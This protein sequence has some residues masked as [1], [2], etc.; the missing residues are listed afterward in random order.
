VDLDGKKYLA[1]VG[2]GKHAFVAPLE[3][4]LDVL[5][6]VSNGTYRL[7]ENKE[8]PHYW[9]VEKLLPDHSNTGEDMHLKVWTTM[10][11]FSLEPR[12][13]SDFLDACHY[14]QTNKKSL[15]VCKS[16]A[17]LNVPGGVCVYRGFAFKKLMVDSEGTEQ[18]VHEQHLKEGEV[19]DILK[20]KFGIVVDKTSFVPCDDPIIAPKV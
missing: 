10:Y 13:T 14:H 17:T 8:Y 20:N 7:V 3:M 15:F 19:K 11:R 6:R 18:V 4:K 12:S 5:Q 16:L 1:D 2:L 9:F